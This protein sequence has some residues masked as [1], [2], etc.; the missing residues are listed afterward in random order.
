MAANQFR[1]T[2]P[3][4]AA[5]V[6]ELPRDCGGAP[7]AAPF[8]RL[9]APALW[10]LV[11]VLGAAV[12]LWALD[13]RTRWE[14]P[15]LNFSLHMTLVGPGSLAVAALALLAFRRAGSWPVL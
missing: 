7:V 3:E 11:L 8:E 5:P 12:L 10:L 6:P 14:P 15:Y 4:A 1:V 13:I 9:Q 2:A